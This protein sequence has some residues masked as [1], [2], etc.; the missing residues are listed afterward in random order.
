MTIGEL[1]RRTGVPVKALRTYTDWGLI[2]SPGRSAGN[3]RLYDADA[4]SCVRMICELR[5]LGLTL[6]EIRELLGGDCA[7]GGRAA[8]GP[9]LVE[10][11]RAARARTEDRIAELERTR[12]RINAFEAAQRSDA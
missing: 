4:L 1:S 5:G 6:A 3:Y 2:H 11:L 12:D 9:L 7:R 8:L 10:R